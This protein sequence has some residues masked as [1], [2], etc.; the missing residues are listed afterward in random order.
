M[1]GPPRAR[2]RVGEGG[3]VCCI[4]FRLVRMFYMLTIAGEH[5]ELVNDV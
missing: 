2:I 3:G 5:M 1:V 4:L